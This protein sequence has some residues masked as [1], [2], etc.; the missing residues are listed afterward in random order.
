[1]GQ[2]IGT[3]VGMLGIFLLGSGLLLPRDLFT[4]VWQTVLGLLMTAVG[5][6]LVLSASRLAA[7]GLAGLLGLLGLALLGAAIV[8]SA[9][10]FSLYGGPGA[11]LRGALGLVFCVAAYLLAEWGSE[12]FGYDDDPF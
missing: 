4:G 1:M 5:F 3:S 11:L 12:I 10:G 9:V 6:A 7:R 8:P 2:F